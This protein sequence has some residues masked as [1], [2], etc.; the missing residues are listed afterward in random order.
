MPEQEDNK[1][2]D[3][4]EDEIKE[5]ASLDENGYPIVD[6]YD[7][8]EGID[9]DK[10]LDTILTSEEKDLRR[11]EPY[12]EQE[13]TE[14][15]E[16]AIS[17]HADVVKNLPVINDPEDVLQVSIKP[18]SPLQRTIE[19]PTE[20]D[21]LYNSL[22]NHDSTTTV[23]NNI[24]VEIAEEAAYLKTWRR[25]NYNLNDDLSEISNKRIIILKKLV[26]TIEKKDK[27]SNSKTNG[28]VDFHSENFQK[29]FEHFLQ[30]VK[31]TLEKVNVPVQYGDI[32][33]SQL[34]KDLDGF[35]DTAEKIYNGKKVRK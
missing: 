32:F 8:L 14:G 4:Y 21:D 33:L 29:V 6:K 25:E 16:D 35:E 30:I 15:S 11:K 9:L 31:N 28:K 20:N 26:E 5:E 24:M 7:I 34:A 23:L 17:F 3:I 18:G 27:I 22:K 2:I 12:T 13:V 19:N 10:D 1:K